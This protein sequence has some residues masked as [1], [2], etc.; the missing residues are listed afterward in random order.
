MGTREDRAHP[1][2]YLVIP[3]I[4]IPEREEIRAMNVGLNDISVSGARVRCDWTLPESTPILLTC[5][6]LRFAAKA[7]IVRAYRSTGAWDLA[8]KF[9]EPHPELPQK[10]LEY[11]L[12]RRTRVR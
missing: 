12:R 8:M 11:K 5:E 4:V 1:R 3:A 7:R 2:E 10:L 6:T 9:N